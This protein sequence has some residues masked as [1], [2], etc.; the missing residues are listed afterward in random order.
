MRRP[1]YDAALSAAE[2][3]GEDLLSGAGGVKNLYDLRL[4]LEGALVR[5]AA[6]HARKDDISAMRQALEANQGAIPDSARFYATDA[7]SMP[8]F[9]KFRRT[10]FFPH[11]QG[12]TAPPAGPALGAHHAGIALDAI[13]VNY[14]S[15]REIFQ[16]I[17]SSVTGRSRSAALENHLS[18]A[19][20]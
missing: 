7:A 6:L 2:A 15:H 12:F 9:T 3:R 8:C 5:N 17:S 1:G 11:A 10:R 19:W 20:E 14:L 18:A 16:A 4:F 13:A